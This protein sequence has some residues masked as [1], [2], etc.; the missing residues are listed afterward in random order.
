MQQAL[1]RRRVHEFTDGRE[2]GGDRFVMVLSLPFE[3]V[4]LAGESGG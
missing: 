2:D 4:E 3:F 1:G